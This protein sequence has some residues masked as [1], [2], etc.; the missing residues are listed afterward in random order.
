MQLTTATEPVCTLSASATHTHIHEDTTM[1]NWSWEMIM[2]FVALCVDRGM[3]NSVW[4][5]KE[6]HWP[7]REWILKS[8]EHCD[9]DYNPLDR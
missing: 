3:K 1:R 9:E 2:G 6:A 5:G 8:A 7:L 4:S